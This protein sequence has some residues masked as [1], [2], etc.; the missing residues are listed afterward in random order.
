[1]DLQIADKNKLFLLLRKEYI[2]ESS[3]KNRRTETQSL[4]D[5]KFSVFWLCSD[6]SL[7]FNGLL[8]SAQYKT[9]TVN[10]NI[11]TCKLQIKTSSVFCVRR[12]WVET[13]VR[14]EHFILKLQIDGQQGRKWTPKWT[15]PAGI[16]TL[17]R[18]LVILTAFHLPDS[19]VRPTYW[20]RLP[21]FKKLSPMP[22]LLLVM[23]NVGAE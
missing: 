14:S 7:W 3:L 19:R 16:F 21:S 5:I 10:S 15:I 8:S 18:S 13:Y 11:W 6:I 1:M 4:N 22:F 23:V 2:C 20:Y 9:V 12:L 17:F